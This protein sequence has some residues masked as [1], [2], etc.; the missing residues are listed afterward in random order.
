MRIKIEIDAGMDE[1]EVIIRCS[2]LDDS[3]VSLQNSI[4]EQGNGRRCISLY[5]GET[6]YYVPIEDIYFFETE[7]KEIH[8]H[9]ADKLFGAAYKLYELEELL[10]AGFM[11]ISKSTIVNLDYIYSITRNLT[12]S[13]VVEFMGSSKKVLVSRGYYKALVERL[14]IRRLGKRK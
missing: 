9:T 1:T 10:P 7:G 3:I 12:A 8:A 14:G 5:K 2:R 11:R 6:A 13:S 4:A